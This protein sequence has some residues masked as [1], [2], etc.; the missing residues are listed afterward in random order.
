MDIGY[1]VY[2]KKQPKTNSPKKTK[3]TLFLEVWIPVLVWG[4]GHP[5]CPFSCVEHQREKTKKNKKTKKTKDLQTMG[6]GL[7]SQDFPNLLVFFGF[8]GFGGFCAYLAIL[9]QIRGAQNEQ[10]QKTSKT[11]FLEV[12]IPVLVWGMG[13]PDCPFSCVEQ[14][15]EKIK[16]TKKQ[17]K[18]KNQRFT[19]YGLRT[20]DPRFPKSF[21]F[22]VFFVF[23][24]FFWFF[25]V[26]VHIGYKFCK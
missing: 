6:S 26:F 23:F 19:N 4:M 21:G 2:K 8:F 7:Q 3:K 20:P 11:M 9:L 25:G 14:Q 16:K 12:W 10:P 17:K 1:K 5:D 13:R 22:L 18:Q 15:R 24:C